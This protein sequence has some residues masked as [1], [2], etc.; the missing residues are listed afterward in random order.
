MKARFLAVPLALVL[1]GTAAWAQNDRSNCTGGSDNATWSA[2]TSASASVNVSGTVDLG[3]NMTSP[4]CLNSYSTFPGVLSVYTDV[5]LGSSTCPDG[6]SGSTATCT[7][8]PPV[9][10]I[11]NNPQ[12]YSDFGQTQ[13]YSVH[14]DAT[15][16]AAG[17]YTF[18]VHANASDPDQQGLNQVLNGFGWGYGGGT[19]LTVTVVQP[20]QTCDPNDTLNVSFA[21]PKNGNQNF[22]TGGT[23]MAVNISA[24]DTSNPITS[25]TASVNTTDITGS[26]ASVGIGTQ[27]ASLSGSYQASKVG[28]YQFVADAATACTQGSAEADVNLVYVISGLQPPLASGSRPKGGSAAPIKIIPRDC[29]GSVVP[30]DSSVH[31][32]VYNSAGTLLQDSFYG[33]CTGTKCGAGNTNV[34]YD[35]STGQ[36]STIFQTDSGI[37][38]YLIKIFFGGVDNFHTNLST[39]K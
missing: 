36:Y 10:S 15:N 18:H 27:S 12:Q 6:S 23:N 9:A 32:V 2:A 26:L 17:T 16:A 24:S 11:T 20:K 30:F 1:A 3:V 31:I 38:T 5:S 28:A 4:T 35:A 14:F 29:S 22:C 13:T 8:T 39:S 34:Q 33:G 25:L 19:D 37:N 7:L 21:N